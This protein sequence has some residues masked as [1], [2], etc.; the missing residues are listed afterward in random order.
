MYELEV[1]NRMVEQNMKC[2]Y[3][4]LYRVL[5]QNYVLNGLLKLC[6]SVYGIGAT[7]MFN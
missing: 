7:C 3:E 5:V 6:V 2:V 1:Q 4:Y